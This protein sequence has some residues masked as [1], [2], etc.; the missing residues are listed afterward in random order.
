MA[1]DLWTDD[2]KCACAYVSKVTALCLQAFFQGGVPWDDY[3]A[4]AL[5]LVFG[6]QT[7]L[8]AEEETA[9]EEA[10]TVYSTQKLNSNNA[11]V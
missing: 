10:G 7:I 6:V 4:V 11:P 9:E 1:M 3:L 5:L 8:S 2:Q